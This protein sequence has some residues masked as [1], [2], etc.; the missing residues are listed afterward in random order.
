MNKVIA[1]AI[2]Q[3]NDGK[4][5]AIRLNKETEEGVLVP[6]GGKL[7]EGETLRKTVIREVK[8]ELGIN[9]EILGLAGIAEEKYGGEYWVVVY[10]R[11]KIVDGTP[12]IMEPGKILEIA[13]VDIEDL[14]NADKVCW[15]KS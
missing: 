9:V 13:W 10:Y 12:K 6:P 7:E 15:V 1:S 2:I 14:K 3:N 8:E 4:V 11:A 5:L